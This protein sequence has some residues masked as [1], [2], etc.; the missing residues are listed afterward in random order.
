MKEINTKFVYCIIGK[1][2]LEDEEREYLLSK[3]HEIFF[4]EAIDKITFLYFCI[5][6]FAFHYILSFHLFLL[7]ILLLFKFHF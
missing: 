2:C 1:L 3:K 7:F 6:F 4:D 5:S